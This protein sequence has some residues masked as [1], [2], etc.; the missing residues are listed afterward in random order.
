MLQFPEE[1]SKKVLSSQKVFL[2]QISLDF[3]DLNKV[4]SNKNYLKLSKHGFLLAK[5]NNIEF[6]KISREKTLTIKE[7]KNFCYLNEDVFYIA[8]DLKTVYLT[9]SSF[10]ILYNLTH[11]NINKII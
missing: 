6:K 11:G 1:L 5:K 3:S 8:N 9:D 2:K 10:Y 4:F 7:I